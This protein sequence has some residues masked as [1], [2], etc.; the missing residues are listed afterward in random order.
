MMSFSHLLEFDSLWAISTNQ[1]LDIHM[2][3]AKVRQDLHEEVDAFAIHQ[4]TQYNDHNYIHDRE[5]DKGVEIEVPQMS[6]LV[7]K[8]NF[9]IPLK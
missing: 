6:K 8:M 9:G 5:T 7:E 2:S 3:G 1:H 4:A